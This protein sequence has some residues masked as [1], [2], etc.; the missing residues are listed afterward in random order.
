MVE[1]D[2][3]WGL[4]GKRVARERGVMRESCWGGLG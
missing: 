2:S 1:G 4:G 3:G